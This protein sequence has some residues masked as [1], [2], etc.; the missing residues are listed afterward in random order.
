MGT[1]SMTPRRTS[2]SRSALT[3]F[4]QWISMGIGEW[5]A[6]RMATGSIINFM[7]RPSIMGSGWSSYVLDILDLW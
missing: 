4:S 5:C 6:V 3:S 1:T 7:G 2:L